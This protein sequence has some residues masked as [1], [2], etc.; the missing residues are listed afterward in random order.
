MTELF[1]EPHQVDELGQT[2]HNLAT[3]VPQLDDLIAG[4]VMG[5]ASSL[6]IRIATAPRSR[7]PINTAAYDHIDLIHTAAY[8]WATNLNDDTTAGWTDNPSTAGYCRHL[9]INADRIATR[10]WAP[11]CLTE[12]TDLHNTAQRITNPNHSESIT[13]R[14]DPTDPAVRHR[15]HQAQGDT[16]DMIAVHHKVT[17]ATLTHTQIRAWAR[18]GKITTHAGPGGEPQYRY[19][20]VATAAL[21]IRARR[22]R[23]NHDLINLDV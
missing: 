11:D 1:L 19:H 17:G 3:L 6:G 23:I 18:D 2:W 15:A 7:P 13:D 10:P 4:S 12:A 16:A 8:G 21:T 22:L 5:V 20:E 14:Y 9:H